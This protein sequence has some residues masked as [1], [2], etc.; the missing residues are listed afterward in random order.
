MENKIYSLNLNTYSEKIKNWD[1][2]NNILNSLSAASLKNLK[3][4]R[5]NNTQSEKQLIKKLVPFENWKKERIPL[6]LIKEFIIKFNN[7]TVGI[8]KAIKGNYFILEKTFKGI[9]I[10]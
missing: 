8:T 10:I 4:E 5:I 1:V 6:N 2:S 7:D 9:K 3:K